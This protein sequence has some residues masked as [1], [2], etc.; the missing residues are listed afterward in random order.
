MDLTLS[1]PWTMAF[2]ERLTALRKEHGLTQRALAQQAKL[3]LIQVHPTKPAT[4]NPPWR[5]SASSPRPSGFRPMPWSSRPPS[6]TPDKEF[7]LQFE[8]LTHKRRGEARRQGR[9]RHPH[10]QALGPQMGPR[11]VTKAR[12][13]GPGFAC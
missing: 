13:P 12:P 6:G 4:P 2:P 11:P 8:A 7:R 5:G 1:L 9:P 3:S 10:P